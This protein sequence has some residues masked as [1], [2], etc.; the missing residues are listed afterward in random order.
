MPVEREQISAHSRRDREAVINP[1]LILHES[2]V[3]RA[4]D[5]R[6]RV[7]EIDV[8]V[9]S[10]GAAGGEIVETR[11]TPRPVRLGANAGAEAEPLRLR[12][13]RQHLARSEGE[14]YVVLHGDIGAAKCTA[15]RSRSGVQ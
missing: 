10:R 8:E 4:D 9:V 2:G 3:L 12:T 1:P 6:A 7:T 11:E 13:E 5:C 15:E 14:R